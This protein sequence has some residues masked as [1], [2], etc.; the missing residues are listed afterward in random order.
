MKKAY[1][2]SRENR[3]KRL[4]D[5]VDARKKKPVILRENLE[6]HKKLINSLEN[7]DV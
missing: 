1:A 5:A 3:I 4:R 6:I 7:A 2:S